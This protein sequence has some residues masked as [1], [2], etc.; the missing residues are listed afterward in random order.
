MKTKTS[1]TKISK[2]I[3]YCLLATV[4]LTSCDYGIAKTADVKEA[5]EQAYFEG[6]RDALENDIRIKRNQDSCW[7][8][9]TSPWDNGEAPIF[10]PSF[11]C[12]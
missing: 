6:Q 8:W 11:E 5:L 12:Q 1:I 4:L 9:T 2:H 3:F 10:D 7:I